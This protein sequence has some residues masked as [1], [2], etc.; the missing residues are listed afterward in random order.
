MEKTGGKKAGNIALG[1]LQ[2]LLL[3][4]SGV[5]PGVSGGVLCVVFGIYKPLM[6]VLA[7]PLKK[8]KEH[9]KTLLPV[10]IGALVGFVAVINVLGGVMEHCKNLAECVFVG[11]ILG[12]IPALVKTA[13]K[14]KR[15]PSSYIAFFAS[16]ASLFSLLMYLKYFSAMVV[17]P[18]FIWFLC[19]GVVFGVSVVLPGLSAYTVLEFFGLF[20]PIVN[21]AVNL[22]FSVLI[23]VGI[24][25]AAALIL[26]SK[27]ISALYERKFSIM[28]HVIL[29]VVVATTLPLV[30]IHFESFSSFLVQTVL[31]IS[32]FIVALGFE[33]FNKTEK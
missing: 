23:P 27:A 19:A 7:S 24:G 28:S 22:D 12:T 2:G 15:R 8:A 13:G 9:I 25:G 3:G 4:A 29:G 11:L 32:G 20:K 6:D 5:L 1:F 31:L 33:K 30:P 18:S 10:G 16:F 17:A 21:G 14:E 26:L